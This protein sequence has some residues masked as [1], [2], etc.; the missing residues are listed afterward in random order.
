MR[1]GRGDSIF[2]KLAAV[3]VL[4]LLLGV[5]VLAIRMALDWTEETTQY[6][7]GGLLT[8]M[9]AALGIFAL[10]FGLLAGIAIYRRLQ[11]DSQIQREEQAR[12]A[13]PL[14]SAPP[15]VEGQ[16]GSWYSLGPGSYDVWEEEPLEAKW[17]ERQ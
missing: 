10:A 17:R 3:P 7:L 2:T 6:V 4:A 15:T 16:P 13:Y 9:G 5:A 11:A 1:E 8:I 14:L 12:G